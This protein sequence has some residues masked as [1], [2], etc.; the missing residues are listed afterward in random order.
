MTQVVV[1]NENSID[2]GTNS[3]NIIQLSDKNSLIWIT[4]KL[5]SQ[6]IHAMIDSGANPNC[7]SFRCVQGSSYLRRLPRYPYSGKQIVDAWGTH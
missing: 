4:V 1:D 2:A 6:D 3:D 5:N 7:I